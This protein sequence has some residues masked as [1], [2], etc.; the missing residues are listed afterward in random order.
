MRT[1]CIEQ[2]TLFNTLWLQQEGNPKQRGRMYTD[3]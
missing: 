1:R 2:G 3:S